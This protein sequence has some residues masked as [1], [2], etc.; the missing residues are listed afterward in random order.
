M[1]RQGTV[2]RKLSLSYPT[3]GTTQ[4][5]TKE[6]IFRL[7][8]ESLVTIYT[9][10]IFGPFETDKNP[11]FLKK[12][13]SLTGGEAFMPDEIS[14]LRQICEKIAHDIRNRYTIAYV[15]QNRQFTGAVRRIKVTA[16]A[17][18]RGRLKVRTRTHYVAGRR[19]EPARHKHR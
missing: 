13:A 3:V 9:V 1:L 18:D 2:T 19:D 5:T 4:E 11:G 12:L 8:E 16:F 10:G 6:E 7:A 14:E 15:P 17:A